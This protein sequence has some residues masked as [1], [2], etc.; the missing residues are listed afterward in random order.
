MKH[1]IRSTILSASVL[2]PFQFL[3]AQPGSNDPTFNIGSGFEGSEFYVGVNALAQQADGK[4]LVGGSFSTF[5]GT[6]RNGIARLNVDGTLDSTF[7]PGTGCTGGVFFG[8][9]SVI[10]L[11]TDGRVLIGGD[12]TAV[13]GVPRNFIARLNA[14]GSVDST[15]DT[16]VGFNS[17]VMALAVRPDGRII[18]GGDFQTFN[19]IARNYIAQLNADGTLDTAFDPG[20]GFPIPGSSEVDD[21][22]LQADGRVLVSGAFN[23]Y[24]GTPVQN[25]VRLETDGALDPSWTGGTDG[26]VWS[27]LR[28]PDGRLFVAG[29]FLHVNGA[30]RSRIARLE[31]DGALDT[32]FNPG[33]GFT[34]GPVFHMALASDGKIVAV[35]RFLE[36]N[37]SPRGRIARL[38]A[39]GSLDTAFDPGTGFNDP[40]G[41]GVNAVIVQPS[42]GTVTGGYFTSFNGTGRNCLARLLGGCSAGTPCDDGDASTVNDV[43]DAGCVCAGVPIDPCTENILEIEFQT[44]GVSEIQWAVYDQ[45]TNALVQT[46]GGVLEGSPIVGWSFCLSNGC[47]YLVVTDDAGDGIT[48]GGYLLRT[49]EPAMRR[50]VDNSQN[51][52]SGYASAIAN[53]EGFCLPVGT[54]RLITTSCDKLDWAPYACSQAFIVANINPNATGYQF[55]FYDP[56]GDFSFKRFQASTHCLLYTLPLQQGVLYNVKVRCLVNGVYNNWGPACRM[57]LNNALAQCPR[58]KLLDLPGNPYLSCGQSRTI[59]TSQLVHARP[60]KRLVEPGPTCSS[61]FWQNANRYQFR[62]RIPSENITIVKTSATGKYWVNTNGLACNKT[63]EVDVRASFDNGATWCHSSDPYGDICLLTTTCSFGMAEESSSSAAG[64]SER[65]VGLYPN[66]NN[67]DQLFV[68]L[69]NVEEG[70]ESINVDIYD[71]FGKRVAQRTLGVQDGFV[72]TTI[73]L[74][75]EL[76]NGMYLVSIAAGSA[77][78]TERLV[79]QK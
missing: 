44:D 9:V 17:V 45:V 67:G 57:M 34:S 16:G 22:V 52:S 55:W 68:S 58:T 20:T 29:D 63:Y 14:D 15:F 4:V 28:Q 18:A 43:L 50:V 35:G 51:F 41:Q 24:N 33:T 59:G 39:D 3:S 79:I 64:Q 66:P 76:A 13:N 48:G 74:N 37:G 21:L 10:A 72:N 5:N 25:L 69:S 30:A 49:V 12:F 31:P 2:L 65:S 1:I 71:S 73:A 26:R 53:N 32:S 8:Y 23:A 27:L 40:V 61:A 38:Q 42:G 54:D 77:I 70:V 6:A 75:G 60:V 11:Q 46:D 56:N 36:F 47:Y 78:H 19:G 62:F 7:D